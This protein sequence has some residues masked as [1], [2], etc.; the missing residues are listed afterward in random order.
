MI[1]NQKLAFAKIQLDAAKALLSEIEPCV[2]SRLKIHAH[3]DAAVLELNKALIYFV[4][5]IANNHNEKKFSECHNV[6]LS[7]DGF[8]SFLNFISTMF[9]SVLELQEMRALSVEQESWLQR[10][11]HYAEDPVALATSFVSLTQQAPNEENV[12]KPIINVINISSSEEA[13]SP[14]IFIGNF[15]REVHS[16]IDRQRANLEEY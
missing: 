16:F 15:I 11:L 12:E 3:F 7:A 8:K 10:L 1:V 2:D 4:A 5:E 6:L 14:E 9:P 13:L